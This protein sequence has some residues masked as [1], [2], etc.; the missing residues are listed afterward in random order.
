MMFNKP[1][2]MAFA[3]SGLL[4]A[5]NPAGAQAQEAGQTTVKSKPAQRVLISQSD[6]EKEA[7]EIR[8]EG[9]KVNVVRNGKEVP[10][11]QIVHEDGAIIVL[12]KDGKQIKRINANI[13]RRPGA[14]AYRFGEAGEQVPF[15]TEMFQQ[16]WGAQAETP[17]VMLG[18]HMSEPGPALEKHLNLESGTTTLVAGLYEGLPAEDAGLEQYDVIVKIDGQ[19]P[20][21]QATIR[22]TLAEKEPGDVVKLTIIQSG[23]KSDVSVT[24][25]EYDREAMA[26]AKVIGSAG[27][28]DQ[29]W[30]GLFNPNVSGRTFIETK[31]LPM[32]VAP[33]DQDTLKWYPNADD[34]RAW[35]GASG[36]GGLSDKQRENL[37]D[38]LQ[39]LDER[40][41][42]LEQLLQ[43]LEKQSR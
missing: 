2:W 18:V 6:G 32:I 16:F 19:T 41:A 12:D 40:L 23:K 25:A 3:A 29:L 31:D 1:I 15:E 13:K 39:R 37:E 4:M 38:R 26:Q 33:F 22:K 11:A 21:D 24:L 10:Q 17:K 36:G 42:K 43:K 35:T 14:F 30:R 34:V 28:E 9:D 7:I 20:A 5:A 8:I 27:P